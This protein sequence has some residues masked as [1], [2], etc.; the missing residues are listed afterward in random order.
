MDVH[1]WTYQ[2]MARE[3][4]R[5]KKIETPSDPM[6]LAVGDQRTYL[7]VAVDHD[8][9]PESAAF[10]AGLRV[11]VLLNGDPVTYTSNHGTALATIN[12]NGPAATTVELP[13]G[14]TLAD[15]AS[16]MVERQPVGLDNGAS[17]TVTGLVRAFFLNRGYLPGPS[18]ARVHSAVI[19][20]AAN[21]VA[22][23]WPTT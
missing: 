12:R 8:T 5:E 4:L 6:T 3:M 14:T 2:V 7:Y 20:T 22:Q 15:V 23:I 11:D 17:L 13:A 16:I 10:G 1:P 19:L 18:L 21:P 9:V